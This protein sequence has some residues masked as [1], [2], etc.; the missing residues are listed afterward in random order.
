MATATF[1]AG[2][3]WGVE[4][5]FRTLPGVT[6]TAVGYM[7]GEMSNPT[8]HDV[9]TDRTGHAE[10]VQVEY[11]PEQVSY[12]RLL[13]VFWDSHDPTQRNR[14]GPDVGTQYRSAIFVHTPEQQTAAEGSKSQREASGRYR[15]PIVTEITPAGPFWRAEEYHQQYL[16]KRGQGSCHI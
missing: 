10:V 9:C 5:A 6:G 8:Y 1:A 3:F 12:E 11:D 15:R 2:C 7:G 4:E 16:L 13:D 14:Q